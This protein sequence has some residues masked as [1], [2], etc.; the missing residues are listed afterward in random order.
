MPAYLKRDNEKGVLFVVLGGMKGPE[1]SDAL[2]RVKSVPGRRYNPEEKRWELPDDAATALRVMQMLEPV[3][4]NDVQQSVRAH[5]A[6]VAENLVTALPT[7]AKLELPWAEKLRPY[8][9]ASVDFMVQHPKTLL[10]DEMGTG[11]TLQSLATVEEWKLRNKVEGK[12]HQ[13]IVCPKS[14]RGTWQNEIEKWLG[15][16]PIAVI[17]GR[18]PAARLKQLAETEDTGGF[19]IVN[20]ESAW[21]DPLHKELAA[22]D[23][24]AVLA[25]EA[26][27]AKNRKAKQTKG[28]WKFQAPLQLALTGTPIMN[29]PDELWSILKWLRP[30]QY[31]GFWPFHYSYVD[32]Y[33][34]RYGTVM[35]G[36]KNADQLRFELSDKM[37]RRT[38]KDV[39]KELP[40]K[41]RQVIPVE[42]DPK[43]K[44]LYREVEEALFLDIAEFVEA[45]D[46]LDADALAGMPLSKLEGLVPN[47]GARIAKL[48]QV[49]SAA[50]AMAA[51]EIIRDNPGKPFVVFTWFV[52]TA[53]NMAET[54][55]KGKPAQKVGTIA[56]NDNPDPVKDAFQNGDL[57]HVIATIAKGGVGLTLTRADTAIFVDEDWV[58]AMNEQAEDR[59]HRIGQKRPVTILVLR[60]PGTVDDGKVAKANDFKRLVTAAVL[61]ER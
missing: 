3:A 36:V 40:E 34:T 21:R 47:A 46:D 51:E 52:D 44:K 27:R 10:A 60:C 49:T 45:H 39:L 38:K 12:T 53:R 31:T 11:K 30:E 28:L 54:L 58:P 42:L 8:Q 22:R 33:N 59:L 29:S 56:G 18:N 7:D 2:A 4:D 26:H 15:E 32:E 9:R 41:T 6:E 17:D 57:D 16:Q 5:T 35:T 23:W 20:W 14:L 55:E 25:D 13:L 43:Q 61:G 50:K 19:V 1:F 24:T 37:V 48:R